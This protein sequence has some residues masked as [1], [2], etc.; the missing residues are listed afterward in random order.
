MNQHFGDD[1]WT[2]VCSRQRLQFVE[3]HIHLPRC[4]R[5][6]RPLQNLVLGLVLLEM[7]FIDYL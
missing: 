2:I 7:P 6:Q 4:Q 1:C 3:Q 5:I